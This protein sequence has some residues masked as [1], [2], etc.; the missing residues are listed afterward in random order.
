MLDAVFSEARRTA[1]EQLVAKLHE[2]AA[3]RR[4]ELEI[5]EERR[6][7]YRVKLWLYKTEFL[8][9]RESVTLESSRD[10]FDTTRFQPQRL[11]EAA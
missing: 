3:R 8:L 6:G 10:S 11:R 1:P 9:S 4:A 7:H 5:A 2:A